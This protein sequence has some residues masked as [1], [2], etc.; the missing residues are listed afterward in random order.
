[1]AG[2]SKDEAQGGRL[3]DTPVGRRLTWWLAM[4]ADEGAR[5]GP[6]DRDCFAPA[7][8]A[9]V[10]PLFEPEIM[11]DEWRR[12]AGRLGAPVD[13]VVE[14]SDGH[15]IVARVDTANGRKWTF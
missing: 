9:E 15:E 8:L 3:A 1:M 4:I 10:A 2:T 7:L 5:V 12:Y 6:Q 14:R 13:V 11:R